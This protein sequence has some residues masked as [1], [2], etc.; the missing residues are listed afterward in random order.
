MKRLYGT[1]ALAL[2]GCNNLETALVIK[3]IAAPEDAATCAFKADSDETL[4]FLHYDASVSRTFI[5]NL[6]VQNNLQAGTVQFSAEDPMDTYT[7]PNIVIPQSF[8]LR[9]ECE[10]DGFSAGLGPLFLPQFSVQQPFCL[11][12]RDDL[13]REVSGV[14]TIR[15]A[16]QSIE[17]GGGLG[18][19]AI[20]PVT[21][22]LSRAISDLF[23][24]A[25]QA[26]ACCNA[27]QGQGECSALPNYSVDLSGSHECDVLQRQFNSVAGPG[28]LS[29]N[30]LED[31]RKFQPFSVYDG[32]LPEFTSNRDLGQPGNFF[33]PAY[34]MR[35]SGILEGVTQNGDLVT[36][37]RWGDVINICNDCGGSSP[38]TGN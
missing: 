19:V 32:S 23:S 16:G 7:F 35:L 31:I 3:N 36:S 1:L 30:S 4:V 9:W 26:N 12:R 10:L 25:A 8:D 22:Q 2:I 28:A 21:E 18:L 29:V 15:A 24:I 14:D 27:F 11:D 20:R 38:C 34:P 17:P 6:Q 13:N 37:A 5:L 33:G